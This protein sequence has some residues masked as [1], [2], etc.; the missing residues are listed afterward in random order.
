MAG[1][2]MPGF[3]VDKQLGRG[4]GGELWAARGRATGRPVVL[5]RLPIADDVASHD[6]VRRAA[7]RLVDVQHPHLVRLR[8]VLSIE[9]AVVLVHDHVAGV[10]L[11]SVLAQRPPLPDAEVVTLAVPLA[12]AL[13][14]IHARGLVHGRVTPASVLLDDDGRPMLADTGV[15]ALLDG[16][17]VL[18]GPSDD[19][20]DL[21]LTCRAA[22]GP[23]RQTGPLATVL[24]AALVDDAARR[25]SAT[26][27]AAAVLASGPAAPIRRGADP[28][29]GRAVQPRVRRAGGA[30][31]R[32]PSPQPSPDVPRAEQTCVS[33]RGGAAG[34]GRR[35]RGG[36]PVRARVGRCGPG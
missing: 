25:P 2:N 19:V 3:D 22:L 13:A 35:R 7:A 34:R 36:R 14:T 5:R 23:A 18:G 16:G 6:H 29:T 30:P 11:E 4:W 12:Q 24:S 21:A 17:D 27:L 32:P 20:R 9:G 8:G 33:P 1:F 26:Q 31:S 28:R 10:C 15:S